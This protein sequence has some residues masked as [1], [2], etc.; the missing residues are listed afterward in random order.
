MSSAA[1]A[2]RQVDKG[3]QNTLTTECHPFLQGINAE[4][5]CARRHCRVLIHQ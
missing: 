3:V 4:I 5:L 1:R 2:I